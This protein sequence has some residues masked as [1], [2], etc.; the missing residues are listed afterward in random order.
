MP[1]LSEKA[2]DAPSQSEAKN[3]HESIS[4]VSLKRW[5]TTHAIC[6]SASRLRPID[7]DDEALFS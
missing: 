7:S 2:K 6:L 4:I 1:A 3:I 5:N